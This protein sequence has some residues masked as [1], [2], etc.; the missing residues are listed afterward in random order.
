MGS[1]AFSNMTSTLTVP[2]NAFAKTY[3]SDATVSL[4]ATP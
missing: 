2:A 3:K 1:Y 4:N